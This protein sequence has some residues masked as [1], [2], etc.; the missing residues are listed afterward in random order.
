MLRFAVL[1]LV[2]WLGPSRAVAS[3]QTNECLARGEYFGLD[4]PGPTP[5]IFAPGLASTHHH[6]DWFPL[7]S[8]DGREVLLRINGKISGEII[9]V[10]F[11]SV[12]DETDCWSEP[13]PLP[14]SGKYP[15]GG[16]VFSP[17]GSHLYFTSKRPVP[18]ESQQSERS[19]VWQVDRLDQGWGEPILLD[20]PINQ[21]NVNGGLG[22]AADGTLYVA[23]EAPM[24]AGGLDIYELAPAGGSYP[25][26]APLR[27]PINTQA[28]EVGPFIDP[29]QRFL[30]YTSFSSEE[31]LSTLISERQE[32][33]SWGSPQAVPVI[34]DYESKFAGLS[35]D[36][37]VLFFVSH[38]QVDESNPM[39]RWSLDLFE[40]LAME[41]NAD[42]YWVSSRALKDALQVP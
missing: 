9:G 27:G 32:D 25:E 35:P 14:F 6:D 22:M 4:L 41:D 34:N 40:D 1:L 26:F 7:F 24:G 16:V 23:M 11:W 17:D 20:S 21:H 29:E 10:L 30:I 2:L 37:R 5:E 13:V 38:R 3:S 42:R 36:G 15:D 19:R 18:G 8:P 28:V 12:M 39:A 33:G 31:G